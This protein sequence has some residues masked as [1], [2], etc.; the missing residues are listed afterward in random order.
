[1]DEIDL[2]KIE[3]MFKHHTYILTEDFQHKLDLIVEGQQ[4]LVEKVGGMEP[5]FDNIEYRLDSL[6]VKVDVIEEK[7]SAVA[8]DL[9]DHRADTEIHKGYGVSGH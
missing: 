2:K 8:A 9:T 5:R 3:D 6:E 4:V 1:M 7:L